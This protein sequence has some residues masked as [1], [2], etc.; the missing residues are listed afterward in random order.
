MAVTPQLVE[1]VARLARL[2]LDA[3]ELDR[4][5]AELN[6]ILSHVDALAEADVSD[7]AAVDGVA[8][9]PVRLRADA[10]GADRL[11]ATPDTI[12]PAWVDGF[13]T[14]PKLGALGGAPADEA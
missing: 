3:A 5:T 7:V 9:G 6:G 2:Q 11:A 14:V 10:P 12:A 13:F 1:H 4:M 8:D